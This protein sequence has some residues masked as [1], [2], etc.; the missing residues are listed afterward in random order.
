MGNVPR[1][2]IKSRVFPNISINTH[3]DASRASIIGKSAFEQYGGLV[4]D[5]YET[6]DL[7][8]YR[9]IMV[10]FI[11]NSFLYRQRGAGDN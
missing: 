8:Y 2:T 10:R 5:L 9:H 6:N 7:Y 3:A 4:L 11:G 1:Q